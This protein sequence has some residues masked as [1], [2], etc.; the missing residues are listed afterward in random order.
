MEVERWWNWRDTDIVKGLRTSW[1]EKVELNTSFGL[2]LITIYIWE[3]YSFT[4]HRSLDYIS[5]LVK[6]STFV[7]LKLIWRY[8]LNYKSGH[9]LLY[10]RGQNFLLFGNIAT[11]YLSRLNVGIPLKLLKSALL[12]REKQI[13]NYLIAEQNLMTL[14]QT[15]NCSAYMT[16][17]KCWK[18]S[19]HNS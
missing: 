16:T 6:K 4:L 14:H 5:F 17:L 13:I 3:K 12:K 9:L 8:P 18:L 2:Q 10:G 15:I 1:N 11:L 19:Y 7:H